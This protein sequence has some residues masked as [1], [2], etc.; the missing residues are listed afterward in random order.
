MGA[1]RF[2]GGVLMG[3]GGGLEDAAEARRKET[4]L[5]LTQ[6]GQTS[7][8]EAQHERRRGLLTSTTTDAGGNLIGITAGGD[9]K[10]LGIKDFKSM[11]AGLGLSTRDNALIKSVTAAETT[12]KG[13]FEGEVVNRDNIAKR[14]IQRG[15]PDLAKLV[16]PMEATSSQPG[17]DSPEYRKADEEAQKIVDEQAGFF[18]TDKTDF[19]KYGGS[20]T[21]AQIAKRKELLGG[22]SAPAATIDAQAGSKTPAGTQDDPHRPTTKAELDA[23]PSGAIY[24]NPSDG[25]LYRKD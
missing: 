10:D 9:T 13:S 16:G 20:R 5:R 4:L 25:K 11:I 1:K 14:L 24:L 18:S 21:Q 22:K 12:G 7:R 23:L 15:R 8:D 2:F 19:A 17:V 6:E 3:I